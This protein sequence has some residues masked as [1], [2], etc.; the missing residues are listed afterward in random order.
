MYAPSNSTLHESCVSID[1]QE[2]G[3]RFKQKKSA[4]L[5]GCLAMR[6]LLNRWTNS[7]SSWIVQP[8][9]AQEMWSE[10]LNTFTKTI[11]G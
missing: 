1:F 7:T 3:Q 10:K 5:R 6:G 2:V 9:A 11:N 8:G 4:S